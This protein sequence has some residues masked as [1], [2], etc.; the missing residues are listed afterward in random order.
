MT[1]VRTLAWAPQ[2]PRMANIETREVRDAG[3]W[4]SKVDAEAREWGVCVLMTDVT[5]KPARLLRYYKESTGEA[6]TA[7]VTALRLRG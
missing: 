6:G 1:A 4:V 7:C 5:S 2:A 3:A